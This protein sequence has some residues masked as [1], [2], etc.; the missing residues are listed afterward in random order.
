[1]R[2]FR[3]RL[4]NCEAEGAFHSGY[5][6]RLA[7]NQLTRALFCRG[8]FGAFGSASAL[9]LGDTRLLAAQTTQIIELRA[10]HL[11]SAHD[12]DRVNHRRIEWEYALH[13][14]AIRDL[15][16]CEVLV[17]PAARAAD[18]NA[19]VGL[20]AGFVAFDHLDVDKKGVTRLKVGNFLTGR[21]FLD[22]LFFELLDDVHCE[23]SVGSASNRRAV[24]TWSEWV[25]ELVLQSFPLVT[26][27]I[28][29]GFLKPCEPGIAPRGPAAARQSAARPPRAARRG[30]CC[31][32]RR[33]APPGS[34]PP[35]RPAVGGIVG[36]LAGL[37]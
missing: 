34:V 33:R 36:I 2:G 11:A 10:P 37:L 22:L 30:L 3:E 23:F 1:M 6:R 9:R 21:K 4:G 24:L 32:H 29:A 17:D 13:A 28:P 7:D 27:W 14:F 31:G 20:H 16:D 8:P 25:G 5:L 19:F 12:H 26:L 35:R 15:A 18:A